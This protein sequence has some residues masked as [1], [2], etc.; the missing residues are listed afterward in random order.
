MKTSI[1]IRICLIGLVF[2]VSK[3]T[4]LGQD[5]DIKCE[6]ISFDLNLSGSKALSKFGKFFLFAEGKELKKEKGVVIA[7][8]FYKLPGT[9]LILSIAAGFLHQNELTPHDQFSMSMILGRKRVPLM[10]STESDEKEMMK[11]MQ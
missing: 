9:K 1:T 6:V 4:V 7:N 11:K 10:P 3:A 5:T 8:K 2:F